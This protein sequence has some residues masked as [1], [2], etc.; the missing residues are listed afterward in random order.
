MHSAMVSTQ[1][2]VIVRW[3][4]EDEKILFALDVIIAEFCSQSIG[5]Q[6]VQL[7]RKIGLPI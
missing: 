5:V 4:L 3:D 2:D 1:F 6:G 7:V